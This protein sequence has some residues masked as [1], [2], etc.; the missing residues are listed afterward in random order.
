MSG[1]ISSLVIAVQS[2][3]ESAGTHCMMGMRI[4]RISLNG[5]GTQRGALSCVAR[6]NKSSQAQDRKGEQ[7]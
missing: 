3:Q 1:S 5:A 7:K 4:R 2:R 6:R